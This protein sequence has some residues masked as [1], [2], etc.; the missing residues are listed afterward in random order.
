MP[1]KHEPGDHEHRA[2][3]KPPAL[4]TFTSDLEVQVCRCGARRFAYLDG[5]PMPGWFIWASR[6][7]RS[8]I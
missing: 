5:E 7:K 2:A 6:T 4:G 8:C 3:E 1:G